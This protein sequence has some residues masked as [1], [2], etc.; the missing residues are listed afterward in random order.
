V[1]FNEILKLSNDTSI[2]S[3]SSQIHS[4]NSSKLALT[5]GWHKTGLGSKSSPCKPKPIAK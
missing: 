3:H 4:G 5:P 2:S 1:P